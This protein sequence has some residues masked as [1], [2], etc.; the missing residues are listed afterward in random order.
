[1]QFTVLRLGCSA[2]AAADVLSLLVFVAET[3][4]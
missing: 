2:A 1:V 3:N 4:D